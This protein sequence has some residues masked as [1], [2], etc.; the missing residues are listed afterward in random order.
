MEITSQT[1]IRFDADSNKVSTRWEP[2]GVLT[3][4]PSKIMQTFYG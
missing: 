1:Q 4:P 2:K 3:H